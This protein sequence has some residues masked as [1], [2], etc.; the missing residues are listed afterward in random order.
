M[1]LGVAATRRGHLIDTDRDGD[2][3]GA[4]FCPPRY[5]DAIGVADAEPALRHVGDLVAVAL[6]LVLVVDELPLGLEVTVAP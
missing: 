3:Q 2:D 6:D 5:L 4:T 1:P